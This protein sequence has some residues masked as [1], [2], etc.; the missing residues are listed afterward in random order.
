M[1]NAEDLQFSLAKLSQAKKKKDVLFGFSDVSIGAYHFNFRLQGE[2][3]CQGKWET[4]EIK[5]NVWENL[6]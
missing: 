6:I 3:V 2:D 1:A 4:N 5:K